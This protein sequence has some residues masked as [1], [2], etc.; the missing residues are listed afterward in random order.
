SPVHGPPSRAKEHHARLDRRRRRRGHLRAHLPRRVG[1]PQ[2]VTYHESDRRRE[3]IHLPGPSLLPL[4][5]AVGI[6]IAIVG[7][8]YSWWF[9]GVGG[10]IFLVSAVRWVLTVR[11]EIESLP[12]ERR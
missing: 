8:I 4:A 7:L 9:V 2:L 12:S 6:A 10:A 1:V 11:E 3:E 5:T